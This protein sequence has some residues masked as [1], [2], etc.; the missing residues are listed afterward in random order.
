MRH[1]LPGV[2]VSLVHQVEQKFETTLEQAPVGISHNTLEGRW[3]W[4]NPRLCEMLGYSRDEL[5]RLT[6]HDVTHPDDLARDLALGQRLLNS[7]IDRY[8]LEKR[9]IRKD[10]TVFWALLQ[11]SLVRDDAGAPA[12]FIGVVQ[13]IAKRKAAEAALQ[14]SERRF[15][16][17]F[18]RSLDAMVV[19]DDAGH[20]LDAN[21]AAAHLLGYDRDQ[22]LQMRVTDILG[23]SLEAVAAKF[24]DYIEERAQRGK[25]RFTHRDGRI[26]IVEF[27]AVEIEPGEHVTIMHD[28]TERERIQAALR[29]TERMAAVGNLA[30]GIVHDMANLLVPMRIGT[31]LLENFVHGREAM[32]ALGIVER[33]V[34]SLSDLTV[35]L[36]H[37]VHGDPSAEPTMLNLPA[38]WAQTKPLLKA[39]LPPGARLEQDFSEPLPRITVNEGLFTRAMLNLITNAADAFAADSQ[40][41]GVIR[42]WA[43]AASETGQVLVGINDNGPGMPPEIAERVFEPFFSTKPGDRASG[44][45][46]A[47][48]KQFVTEAGG[49][50]SIDSAPGK[51]TKVTLRLRASAYYKP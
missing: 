10:G 18:E 31:T 26:R 27:N 43:T 51:G 24:E 49:T 1:L 2:L 39:A 15:R 36:R 50:V 12:Y 13:D 28:V 25:F 6:L 32:A 22:L 5:V 37:L 21:P 20:Y 11:V 4:V 34:V 29:D 45:G 19:V 17:L 16:L 47:S 40:R 9:Y 3:Q 14:T 23:L 48:V 35:C 7:E 44:L 38:W 41:D 46:M 33:G 42:V 30:A 8:T